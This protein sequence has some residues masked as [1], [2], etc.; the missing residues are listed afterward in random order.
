MAVTLYS[1]YDVTGSA[2]ES[3]ENQISLLSP[4]DVPFQSM[5]KKMAI[6]NTVHQWA[7]DA[8]EDSDNTAQKEG[9]KA[10]D[11]TQAGVAP[12]PRVTY[13]QI[14]AEAVTVSDSTN[15]TDLYGRK[16]AYAYQLKKK[17]LKL[18]K[19]VEKAFLQNAASTIGD[20][21][22][23]R[24]LGGFESQVAKELGGSAGAGTAPAW[25]SITGGLKEENIWDATLALYTE[26][27][28]PSVI[29][30]HPSL[31]KTI[32]TFQEVGENTGSRV[33]M[34]DNMD[35]TVNV[36]VKT[37]IDP[38]GQNIKVIPNREMDATKV[39]IF[40]PSHWAACMFRNFHTYETGKAGSLVEGVVEVELALRHD[41]QK[42]SAVLTLA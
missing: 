39:F 17:G 35:T 22:T 4:V 29:M 36:E 14:L 27:S 6:N 24:N 33:R 2:K 30:V 19:S 13:T 3:F 31:M 10:A 23:A 42:A 20:A 40:N 11:L 9:F 32:S 15:A 28:T 25:A 18:K 41:N 38:L 12:V 1:S 34:F 26:G 16:Q 37:L 8:L 5:I 21:T 7:E